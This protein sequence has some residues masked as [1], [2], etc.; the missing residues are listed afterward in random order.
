M[1]GFDDGEDAFGAGD[2]VA[3][4][5]HGEED[6]FD[7]VGAGEVAGDGVGDE[8]GL[9]AELGLTEV[10]DSQLGDADDGEGNSLDGDGAVDCGIRTSEDRFG[11]RSDKNGD[12]GVGD[13]VLLVE[14]TAGDEPEVAH[15]FVLRGDAED[16]GVLGDSV[17]DADVV[18]GL[19]HGGVEGDVRDLLDDCVHVFA[20]HVVRGGG[21][22]GACDAAAGELHFDEVGGDG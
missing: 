17:A 10:G 2:D 4:R 8:N 18:V 9:I 21:V 12:L 13:G 3:G 20:G 6:L 14:E 11:K 16:Q 22:V 15:V 5:L 7:G 19:E 1:A